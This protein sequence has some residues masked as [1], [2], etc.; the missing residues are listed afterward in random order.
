M[1]LQVGTDFVHVIMTRFNLATPGRESRIRLR[2]GWLSERFGLFER[3]CLPSIAA[4]TVQTFTWI[5]YFDEETPAEFRERIEACRRVHPFVAYFSPLFPS[6]GWPR[7]VREV[8]APGGTAP[9]PWLLSTRLD[10]DD[11]L[12]VD[13]V[14]RLQAAVAAKAR[15]ERCSLNLT[16]GLVLHDGRVYDHTHL[17]NA[18][19]SW[20][21]PWDD[22]MCTAQSIE[23]MKMDQYGPIQQ[24]PGPPAWLQV[25]HGG[26]VSN[27]IRGRRVPAGRARGRFPPELLAGLQESSSTTIALENLFLTPRRSALD[28]A[29]ALWRGQKRVSR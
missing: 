16:D 18:F 24:V 4:Q 26:N 28:A 7:S 3:Y 8:L 23:H 22:A 14:Q 20:L 29:S 12:A 15:P 10:N 6:E 2:P 1:G 19:A 13:H 27:K 17:S 21:E 11:G 25:V 5:I 9:A